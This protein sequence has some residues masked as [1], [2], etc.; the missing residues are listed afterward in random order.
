MLINI[1]L[2]ALA[3]VSVCL[4]VLLFFKKKISLKITVISVCSAL[5]LTAAAAAAINILS[6]PHITVNGDSNVTIPVF[7]E[8]HEQGAKAVDRGVDITDRIILSGKVDT[9]KV[10]KYVIEY[11][12]T[13]NKKTYK[14]KRSVSVVDNQPPEIELVGDAE[15]TASAL[16]LFQDEG[17]VARDNYDGDL[18]DKIKSVCDKKTNTL[19]EIIYTAEDSSGNKS[20]IKRTVKIKDVVAPV[21]KLN[22]SSGLSIKCGDTFIDGGATA[23]DDLDGD[24]SNKIAVSGS[25]DS[26]VS[27]TYTLTYTVSD[28]SGN[29][30]TAERKIWVYP[31]NDSTVSKICLTFDDGPSSNVTVRILDILKANDVKATFFIVDYSEDKLPIIRRMIDEGH[32]IGIHGY[33]HD[34][35]KIYSSEE[36]FMENVSKLRTKLYNDTGY[37]THFMR[38]PGGSSNTVSAKYNKGIM[39]RLVPM[40]INRGYK[41][42]DWNI[43]S[44]DA[45]GNCISANKILSESIKG[46]EHGRTNII[47]MHD[48]SSKVTTADALQSIINYGKSKGY[49]FCAIDD[50]TPQ[51]KHGINN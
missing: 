36:V 21:I 5:T 6:V 30:A 35:S 34:Y 14:T 25:V 44:S 3:V 32:T 11:Q 18:T 28:K 33:S 37:D 43:S 38:F 42:F 8:Y 40:V 7:S 31:A 9:S 46:L 10:G 22:G 47:L 24:I 48:S 51:I 17:A 13:K 4:A 29:K 12:C 16:G 1:A 19:Y 41:Y 2:A 50:D 26:N 49:V 39:S 23:S 20:Q 15:V 27:G 45:S